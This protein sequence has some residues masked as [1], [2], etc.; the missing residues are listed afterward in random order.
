MQTPGRNVFHPSWEIV[1][2]ILL[3]AILMLATVVLQGCSGASNPN[4]PPSTTVNPAPGVTL[5]AIQI[6][7]ATPF[8]ALAETRQLFA[9]GVYSDGSSV[10]ITSQVKWSASI[11]QNTT[12]SVSVTSA[13]IVTG[14]A[15]GYAVVTATAGSVEGAQE[16]TVDTNGYTSSTIAI[17]SVPYKSS[18]ID[19]AYIPENQSLIQG[20]YAVQEVNLDADQFS[21]VL[22]VPLALL[23]S[24][25]M[26]P[27]FVPNATIA[28]AASS[29]VAVISYSSPE[30][31]V[32]DASNLPAFDVSNNTV[33]NTFKAPVTQTVTFNGITCMICAAVM[34]PLNNQLLLST[35]QGY[36]SMDLKAG[37]F[38]PLPF[39]SSALPAPTFTLNPIASDPYIVSSTFTQ[40]PPTPTVQVLDL[41]TNNVT[42]IPAFGLQG[43]S[44]L[45][46]DPV[47]G[48]AALADTSAPD[49]IL[50]NFTDPQSPSTTAIPSLGSC[51]G[52]TG[53]V[54]MGMSNLGIAANVQPSN[55]SPTLYLSQVS[56]SCFGFEVWTGNPFD[57]SFVQY[58]YGP[59]PDAPDGSPFV[60]GNDPNTIASFTSVVDKKNYAVL[61]N[62]GQ[63][64]MAKINPQAVLGFTILSGLPA[65]S[66]ISPTVL[67]AG[68]SGDPVIYLPTPASMVTLSVA[69]LI[70]GSQAVGT[71]SPQFTITLANI[72]QNP[73]TVSQIS[74]QGTNPGDFTEVDSCNVGAGALLAQ[75]KCTIDITFTPT[76]TGARSAVLT[77]TDNGGASPQTVQLSGTGS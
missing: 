7:P 22:P 75:S 1:G 41:T 61:V 18:E 64:W 48:F 28:S 65:G 53:T 76:A 5:Q 40:N 25:P 73:L 37:T 67:A 39:P 2:E 52:T 33:V 34:N 38:T 15:L 42:S 8:I 54:P 56:G 44:A 13:G 45:P 47:T 4:Y 14:V 55:V 12:G 26:P 23:A 63:N 50:L 36:F 58:G 72:G 71:P 29:L 49:Q 17:L 6:T 57:I 46:L 9:T 51:A 43:P 10:D 62:A 77:V 59:M 69:N 27:G 16:F 24:I 31:Q 19:A 3:P 11:S 68:V 74:I 60:N 70:F 21:S 66:L 35:A 20:A 30:I 32:I